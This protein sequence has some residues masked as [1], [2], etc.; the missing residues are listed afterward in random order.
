MAVEAEYDDEICNN[1]FSRIFPS[2]D[3]NSSPG[4]PKYAITV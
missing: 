2:P 4:Q 1:T 3:T